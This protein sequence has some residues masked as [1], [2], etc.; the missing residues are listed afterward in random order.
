MCPVVDGS[1]IQDF[2]PIP[3]DTYNCRLESFE[4]KR[5]NDGLSD[6]INLTFVVDDGEFAGRKL[7][8]TQNLKPGAL[9]NL[10][11]TCVALGADPAV[12]VGSFDTDDILRELIGNQCRIK[13]SIQTEGEYA[14]RQSVDEILGQAYSLR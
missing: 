9:W 10:K 14:G 4:N 2:D 3:N 13:A 12:F 1:S 11:K 5:A 6:N 8:R 7:F